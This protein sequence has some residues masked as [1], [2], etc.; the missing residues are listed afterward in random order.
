MSHNSADKLVKMANQIGKFFAAQRHS[1]AV[2]GTAEHLKKFWDPRMRAGIIAHLEHGGAGL[3]P[4][5]MEAVQK[6][7]GK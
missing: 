3:D 4:V 7:A 5:P 2:A 6:L 1:D